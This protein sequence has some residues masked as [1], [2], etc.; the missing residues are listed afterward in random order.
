VKEKISRLKPWQQGL[1]LLIGGLFIV[2]LIIWI[3]KVR[4]ALFSAMSPFLFA[5]IAAY[6]LAPLVNCMER[7]R[8][9]RPVA[10]AVLYIVFAIVIFI[11]CVRVVPLF[12]D[13]LQELARQLPS[14][15]ADLQRLLHRMEEGYR[16]FNLPP[17]TREIIDHNIDTLSGALAVQMERFYN[18]VLSLFSSAIIFLLVPVLTYYFLRDE[19]SFKKRLLFLFPPGSRRSITAA[20]E[21][22]NIALGAFI[23][24]TLLVSFAVAG[25]TYAG[26]LFL[27]VRFPLV[28][29]IVMGITN[30]IPF[31]GPI[32]GAIPVWLVAFLDSPLLSLKAVLLIVIIQQVENQLIAP[33]VIGRS[34]RLHPL[35]IILALL[36][37]GKLFGFIGLI[38]AVPAALVLRILGKH[39]L[40][41]WRN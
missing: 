9:S 36:L 20:A 33:V 12:L 31:I 30:L 8:I 26:F 17:N 3:I 41:F 40:M 5:L 39:L 22:I 15:A 11:F 23:R 21:E 13:D 37:G 35:T 7:R 29:A 4:Q 10:I 38:L 14:Y 34:A 18:M 1:L 19:T 32:I 25:L 24:G 27:G 6:L 16:R 28:L 2:L